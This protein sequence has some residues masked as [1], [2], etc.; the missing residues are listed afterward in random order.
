MIIVHNTNE[1]EAALNISNDQRNTRRPA[2][3]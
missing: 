2:I 1:G 3:L